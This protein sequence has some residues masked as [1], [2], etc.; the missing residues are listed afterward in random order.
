L[1]VTFTPFLQPIFKTESLSLYEFLIVGVASSLVFFAVEIEKAI[2]RRR[3][4]LKRAG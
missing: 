3:F 2:S 1:V 4:K